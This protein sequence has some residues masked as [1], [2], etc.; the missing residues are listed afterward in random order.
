MHPLSS[1]F[2]VVEG[3]SVKL[4]DR[5]GIYLRD[6]PLNMGMISRQ[7]PYKCVSLLSSGGVY[8]ALISAENEYKKIGSM[9]SAENLIMASSM[10]KCRFVKR[11]ILR[12]ESLGIRYQQIIFVYPMEVSTQDIDS[13]V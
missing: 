3:N 8:E 11:L 12:G 5:A 10:G 13:L 2:G 4:F 9:Q 6:T 1:D 7:M